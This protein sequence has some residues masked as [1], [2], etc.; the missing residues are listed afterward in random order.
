MPSYPLYGVQRALQ[1][2]HS[3]FVPV[4]Q[5]SADA[6][7]FGTQVGMTLVDGE[8][9]LQIISAGLA[10]DPLELPVP[11]A[12]AAPPCPACGQEMVRRTARRGAHSSEDFWCCSAFPACRA[13][14]PIPEGA[15]LAR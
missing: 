9:L 12:F 8:E 13:T 7:Q 5:Y 14:M 10:G 2:E 6:Q 15:T 4:G 3:L 11:M 1:V